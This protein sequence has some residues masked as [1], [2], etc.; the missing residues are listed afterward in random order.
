MGLATQER[1]D[2]R[3]LEIAVQ[4]DSRNETAHTP[5][6]PEAI[7]HHNDGWGPGG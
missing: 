3:A 5:I 2:N 6:L 7:D 1:T 4:F